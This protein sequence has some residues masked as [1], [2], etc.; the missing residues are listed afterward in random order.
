MRTV[1]LIASSIALTDQLSKSYI[2]SNFLQYQY[3]PVISCVFDIRYIR[4]TG[5]AYGMFSDSGHM[6]IILSFV[7]LVLLA[8]FRKKIF[9]STPMNIVSFGLIAGGITGNLIDRLKYGYVV[10]FL[11]FHWGSHPF[12][13]FNI[14]DSAIC[15]GVGLYIL[16]QYLV[17]RKE[18]A[19]V[20]DKQENG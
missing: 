4:N 19:P 12:P 6:L 15:T 10:D 9:T 13:A 17:S 20:P 7:M 5:A 16:H 11:D 8:I 18:H 2:I 14:A 1:L 3:I